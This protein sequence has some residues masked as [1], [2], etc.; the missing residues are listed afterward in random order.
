MFFLTKWSL[1]L[2][3]LLSI[4]I[5]RMLPSDLVK[6]QITWISFSLCHLGCSWVDSVRL[7]TAPNSYLRQCLLFN[8][9]CHISPCCYS[10]TA[11]K[12]ISPLMWWL[13]NKLVAYSWA[14]DVNGQNWV[15]ALVSGERDQIG[16][17]LGGWSHVDW[18]VT[19]MARRAKLVPWEHR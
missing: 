2:S 16:M 9:M 5:L 1:T 12:D 19:A 6:W 11:M 4:H 10:F 18:E 3:N 14:K 13:G 17:S 7:F 8:S 15:I